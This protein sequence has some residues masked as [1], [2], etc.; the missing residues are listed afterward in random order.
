MRVVDL[1][2][3]AH[4][5]TGRIITNGPLKIGESFDLLFRPSVQ[6]EI[7][8]LE[9]WDCDGESNRFLFSK[10]VHTHY[11]LLRPWPKL[12]RSSWSSRGGSLYEATNVSSRGRRAHIHEVKENG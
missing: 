5:P 2:L 7:S 9:E 12:K 10:C 3:V 4:G 8:C 6:Y 1:I 11:L